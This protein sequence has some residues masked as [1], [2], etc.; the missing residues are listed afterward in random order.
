MIVRDTGTELVLITQPEHAALAARV[1]AS[2]RDRDF[3]TRSSREA[4]LLATRLHDGGWAEEDET[5]QWDPASGRP[6]EF[7]SHPIA[8]RQAL[9]PRGVALAAE[10]STYVAAL[11][12]Q[13][14]LTAYRH[15][16]HDG[17]WREFFGTMEA[18][19]D[20]WFHAPPRGPAHMDP[21][22]DQRLTFLQDYAIVRLGDLVSLA[23]CTGWPTPHECEGYRIQGDGWRVR[24]T[25]DPFGGEPVELR[26]AARQLPRRAFDSADELAGAWHEAPVIELVGTA[27]GVAP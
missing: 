9:W 8:R 24:V 15:Y 4:A 1:M 10:H 23:F 19:R 12:A 18:L 20:T 11:V 5:P 17:Q 27:E 25:P 22:L 26:V 13:H 14:A 7:V 6:F 21:P 16:E 2:W 3:P